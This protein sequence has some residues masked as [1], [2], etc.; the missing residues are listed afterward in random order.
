M[1]TIITTLHKKEDAVKIG[2]GLLQEHL[3]ACYNLW[4]VESA[5]WWKGKVL[6]ENEV[7]MF[8]KSQNQNFEQ[9]RSFIKEKSGYEVPEVIAFEPERVDKSFELWVDSE[10]KP[11]I[12]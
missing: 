11:K 1:I 10:T 5:Y 4:P 2:K 8:M 3:I 12:I 7:M 9:I 6:E